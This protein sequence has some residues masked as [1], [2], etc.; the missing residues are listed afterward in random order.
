MAGYSNMSLLLKI[1][2]KIAWVHIL[3]SCVAHTYD[4]YVPCVLTNL[5]KIWGRE[6]LC[7]A[8]D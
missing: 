1:K 2:N 7:T 4:T 3:I 8:F 5:G 6:S